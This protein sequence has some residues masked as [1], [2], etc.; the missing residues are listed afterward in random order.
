M[1]KIAIPTRNNEVDNHFG[2]CDFYTIYEVSDKGQVVAEIK[3]EAP[4]GCGCKSGVGN[5]LAEQGVST[6]LA[7]SMGRG[8]E[9]KI[10]AAGID[11]IK[12]CTGP[13]HIVIQE[14]IAGNLK[15]SGELCDHTHEDGH[16]CGNH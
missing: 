9:E 2:H 12:G 10:K 11:M 14:Y 6:L 15:D 16:E 7:G 5:L 1:K 4:K 13:V 3:Y 8:A